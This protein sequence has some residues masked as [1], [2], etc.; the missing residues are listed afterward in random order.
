MENKEIKIKDKVIFAIY[1]PVG[2]MPAQEV[3]ECMKKIQDML[4]KDDSAV[5]FSF[6]IQ[7]GEARMECVYPTFVTNDEV[8]S[9]TM[10]TLDR[11]SNIIFKK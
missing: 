5:F 4:P 6:P 8:I 2:S 3:H 9:K 7:S 1:V 11:F 10:E